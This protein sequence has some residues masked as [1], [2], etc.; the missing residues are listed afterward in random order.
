M[1]N[2]CELDCPRKFFNNENFPDYGTF[3]LYLILGLSLISRVFGHLLL[4]LIGLTVFLD[5]L[6]GICKAHLTLHMYIRS[7]AYVLSTYCIDHSKYLVIMYI[8]I[9]VYMTD[10]FVSWESAS[11][12][13]TEGVGSFSFTVNITGNIDPNSV[14]MIQLSVVAGSAG[15]IM[16]CNLCYSSY[17]CIYHTVW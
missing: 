5:V 12:S 1:I 10:V 15:N 6:F 9:N 16:Y 11:M 17:V 4:L 3:L 13:V 2:F 8:F 14:T 7:N